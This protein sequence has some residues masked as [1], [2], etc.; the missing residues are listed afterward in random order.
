MYTTVNGVRLFFDVEGAK[1]VP[2]GRA[3]REKPT[4]LV[5]HG[6]PGGDHSVGK[7]Y[8]SQFTD[9]AQIVYYDQRGNGRS[10]DGDPADW[11]LAQ[12]GDDVKALCDALGIENPIVAGTSF[13]GFVTLSYA[14]RHPEHAGALALISTA[15]KVD[16]E[17]IYAAFARLGGD[18]IA[19]IARAYWSAPTSEGRALYRE[20]CVPLYSRT[21]DPSPDWL[22]R[23]LWRDAS[24]LHFNGPA[25]EHGQME[26][27]DQLD[28]ITCPV[29]LMAGE[30]DPITPPVFSDVIAQGLTNA[31]LTYHRLAECGHGI[32]ADHPDRLAQELRALILGQAEAF[33]DA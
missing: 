4:L 19:H 28:K 32:V 2:D 17:E 9:I 10:E 31:P 1:L 21:L 7:P 26:L 15:A 22:H 8:Y 6:G 18:E 13:G 5:V 14:T 25:N 33:T 12:W 30:E 29:L 23:V 27:R 3:M 11:T 24:A 20:R 16:F